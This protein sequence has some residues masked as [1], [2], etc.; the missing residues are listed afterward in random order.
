MCLHARPHGVHD[1][2]QHAITGW[3]AIRI[4]DLFKVVNV[5]QPEDDML[6]VLQTRAAI[7]KVSDPAF[8]AAP[9]PSAR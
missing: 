8:D 3:M 9:I 2:A 4:V 7:D 1:V 5:D 6:P